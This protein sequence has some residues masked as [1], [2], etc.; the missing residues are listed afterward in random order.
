MNKLQKKKEIGCALFTVKLCSVGTQPFGLN[1]R[2]FLFVSEIKSIYLYMSVCRSIG[3]S[4]CLSVY[5]SV[6]P[7]VRPS[8]HLSM[9]GNQCIDLDKFG[10]GTR[11]L[12]RVS[13]I[14]GTRTSTRDP[15][16][17]QSCSKFHTEIK[18]CNYTTI[19]TTFWPSRHADMFGATV[20]KS[21]TMYVKK[22]AKN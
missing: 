3:L 17:L 5:L 1:S 20:F 14:P 15:Q 21:R 2:L 11:I 16:H 7:S 22:C 9:L 4:V 12:D 6:R 18:H 10:S 13:L 19:S 8:I